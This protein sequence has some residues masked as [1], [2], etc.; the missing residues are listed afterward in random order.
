MTSRGATSRPCNRFHAI[1]AVALGLLPAPV[2][3]CGDAG[4]PCVMDGRAFV[5]T[6]GINTHFVDPGTPYPSHAGQ[7]LGTLLQAHLRH[8]RDGALQSGGSVSPADQSALF[9]TLAGAGIH[10]DFITDPHAGPGFLHT[11]RARVAPAAEA[12]ELPNEP[13]DGRDPAWADHTRS[14]L[15]GF[16]AAADGI[17]VIGPAL[18]VLSAGQP[19]DNPYVTLGN[20]AALVDFGNI[21]DYA[22]GFSPGTSGW[23]NAAAPPCQATRYGSIPFNLCEARAAFGTRPIMATEYGWAT[24]AGRHGA[25]PDAVQANYVVRGL[26]LQAMAG[27]ARTY[28]YQ[29]V[30]S[31]SDAGQS[32]GLLRADLSAKPSFT[33]LAALLD[34]ADDTGPGHP[35]GD[36]HL[37][38]DLA[39]VRCLLLRRPTGPNRLV[40]WVERPSY[41]PDAR[42]GAGASLAPPSQR[43]SLHLPPSVAASAVH[44]F[45]STGRITDEAVPPGLELALTD[46]LAVIDLQ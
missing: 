27:V 29:L 17:P 31:G 9:R 5:D 46:Q 3:A 39:D 22:A 44:R 24:A 38:G 36:I 34:L 16:R 4:I 7:L 19:G 10:T 1:M 45:T 23:G 15:Q 8:I 28:I 32:M 26:L 25:V 33:A 42:G 41:D 13:N 6:V 12:F 40:A 18:V 30:D 2:L 43:V 37:T 35:L 21:H 14:A 11:F 20:Q